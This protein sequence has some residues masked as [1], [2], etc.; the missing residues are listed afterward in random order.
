MIHKICLSENFKEESFTATWVLYG[1]CYIMTIHEQTKV[2]NNEIETATYQ[3]KFDSL[4]VVIERLNII[5]AERTPDFEKRNL[6][7]TIN[8]LQKSMIYEEDIILFLQKIDAG[9][10]SKVIINNLLETPV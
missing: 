4:D 6:V 8:I 9:T 10:V 1:G 7:L 3:A 5:L 2:K